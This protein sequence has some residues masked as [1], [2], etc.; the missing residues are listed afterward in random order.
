[1][2]RGNFLR[3]S[4]QVIVV[5]V[6]VM[7][8]AGVYLARARTA[9]WDETLWVTVYPIIAD[10]RERTQDYVSRLTPE[11]FAAVERFVAAEAHR[12][13]VA[14][15]QPVRVDLGEPV[16]ELPPPPPE[17]RNPFA[18]GLWSLK[19]RWW[20][21]QATDGQSGPT[22]DV[23]MFVAYHDPE[24]RTTVPHSLGLQKSMLGV[25]HAFATRRMAGSN[26]LVIAH[27]LLHTLGATDKYDP[28]DNQPIHP[29]GF[30]DPDRQPLYPQIH[31]EIMGGR[32]PVTEWE[33]AIPESLQ[34]AR[35]GHATAAE[36]N[37]TN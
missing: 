16:D 33:A 5:T 35:V 31:A 37:W 15:E 2:A 11:T 28:V 14:I 34:W 21:G 23:R 10:G 13:G 7:F 9:S 26:N 30:A 22:P 27:E 20:A 12:Y 17:S 19:I 4:R 18:V 25:V 3:V 1:M 29:E 24:I 32:I 8:A 6:A 36:L